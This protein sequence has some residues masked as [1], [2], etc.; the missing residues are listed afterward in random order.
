MVRR[1]IIVRCRTSMAAELTKA[2]RKRTARRNIILNQMVPSC[3]R[4][5]S[6]EKSEESLEDANILLDEIKEAAVEMKELDAKVSDLT[7]D[8][9]EFEQIEDESYKMGLKLKKVKV[10]LVSFLESETNISDNG[11]KVSSDKTN[12]GIKLPNITIKT[13]DGDTLNW[14]A[15]IESFNATIYL[16]GIRPESSEVDL[17]K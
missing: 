1:R 17:K 13:I 11:V 15:F 16:Q 3:E 7:E 6:H 14:N 5:L 2:K 12:V 8:D 4:I 9:A 10:K